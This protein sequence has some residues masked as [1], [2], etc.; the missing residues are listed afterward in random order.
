LIIAYDEHGGFFDHV[1][2]PPPPE[3]DGSGYATLGVR[4]PALLVG[5][6]LRRFVCHAVLEHTSLIATILRRFARDPDQ[7]IATMPRR[8]Q[9]APDLGLTLEDH[10]RNDIA[11]HGD[12]REQL[13]Q[14]RVKSRA[15][16]RG[17]DAEPSKAVDGAGHLMPLHDFQE[18]FLR[19]S[20][21]MREKGLPPGQP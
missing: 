6:R 1:S 7:A 2:P 5:P 11:D 9:A 10:P 14:W 16:R 20:L 18:D 8:V 17:L 3:H 19:F 15:A 4:V 13:D 21:A 12:L